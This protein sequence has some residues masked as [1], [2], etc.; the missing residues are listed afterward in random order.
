MFIDIM[1]WLDWRTK[2]LEKLRQDPSTRIP[3]LYCHTFGGTRPIRMK[4]S[5]WYASKED[6]P[7]DFYPDYCSGWAY[8]ISVELIETL[9]SVSNDRKFFWVDD[10]F[11]TGA[12]MEVAKKKY[13]FKPE[14]VH[15]WGNVTSD[16]SEYRYFCTRGDYSAKRE[17]RAVAYIPRDEYFERD[18][19]CMWNKTLHDST[20]NFTMSK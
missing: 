5:K 8:G 18:M 15:I 6:W 7:E 11:A 20:Y 14:V 19:M 9:Y 1:Q 2:D 10:V 16:V 4:G 12:L 13:N 17:F 3:D